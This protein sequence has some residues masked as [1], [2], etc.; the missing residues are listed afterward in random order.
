MGGERDKAYKGATNNLVKFM[1]MGYVNI[2]KK[3]K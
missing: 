3:L 1:T 2:A